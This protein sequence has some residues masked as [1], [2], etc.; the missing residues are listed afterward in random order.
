MTPSAG[1]W[2]LSPAVWRSPAPEL[3]C[4]LPI[5]WARLA[6]LTTLPIYYDEAVHISLARIPLFVPKYFDAF[7]HAR[8]LNVMLLTLFQP[9]GLESLWLSRAVT[10]LLSL[11][12][13][14]ATYY[15][16]RW[17]GGRTT[18]RLA[19][20]IYAV[21]PFAYFYDR[22]AMSDP[23]MATFGALGLVFAI[24]AQTGLRLRDAVLAGILFSLSTLTKFSGG[25]YLA[26]PLALAALMPSPNRRRAWGL[27]ILQVV[28]TA[29]L[30]GS[31]FYLAWKE[32]GGTTESVGAQNWCHSPQCSGQFNISQALGLTQLNLGYYLSSILPFYTPVIWLLALLAVFIALLERDRKL[33]FL[34]I[35][36]FL[37]ILPYLPIA[38]LFP[39]RYYIHTL[40]PLAVLAAVGA[41]WC[42]QRLTLM[43]PSFQRA[44]QGALALALFVPALWLEGWQATGPFSAPLAAWEATQYEAGWPSSRTVARVAGALEQLQARSGQRINVIVDH[45]V[46][47]M[48]LEMYAY[49]GERLGR[50]QSLRDATEAQ[51]IPWVMSGDPLYLLLLE[52]R[53][54]NESPLLGLVYQPIASFPIPGAEQHPDQYGDKTRASLYYVVGTSEALSNDIATHAYGDP[55]TAASSYIEVANSVRGKTGP[56]LLYPSNQL[57][58]LR[59]QRDMDSA[60]LQPLLWPVEFEGLTRQAE[61]A[62]Q[63]ADDVWA[64]F[65]FDDRNATSPQL[66]AWFYSTLYRIDTQYFGPIKV[67]HYKTGTAENRAINQS[68]GGIAE[69]SEASVV[70]KGDDALRVSLTWKSLAATP[71]SYKVFT[72]VF[73]SS[74]Q[75][76]AQRDDYPHADLTPTN[77]W[78]V[79]QEIVDRFA[80][81]LPFELPAGT[82]TVK[83]GLYDPGSGERLTTPNGLDS[84]EIGQWTVP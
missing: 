71:T 56:I 57:E 74:G 8:W 21:M 53:D 51:I 32:N 35:P 42:W 59:A 47:Y 66:Q 61:Q 19:L 69:L 68:F 54:P 5:L 80:V 83:L 4:L 52:P 33:L 28:I 1:A 37:F 73:D 76:I 7:V 41:R 81:S 45:T 46:G 40:V 50:V 3:L 65:A 49:W 82:Y 12:T 30:F 13:A 72:H 6:F 79:G 60:D 11:L 29:I 77:T 55:A 23:I 2:R 84:I 31:I 20:L 22:Q 25:L 9:L 34:T 38:D 14:A 26:L 64:V 39:P 18:A 75:L 36:A 70:Y 62:T 17:V 27:A 16:G 15:M 67:T 48:P 24:R 43:T 10:V 63:N 58:I 44:S 78:Q